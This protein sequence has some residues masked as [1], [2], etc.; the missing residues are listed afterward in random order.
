MKVTIKRAAG[1]TLQDRLFGTVWAWS[2]SREF[3]LHA[4]HF[5]GGWAY[6]EKGARRKAERVARRIRDNE[7]I[8]YSYNPAGLD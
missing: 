8:E 6:S 7:H 2:A 5:T 3:G 1:V 4:G